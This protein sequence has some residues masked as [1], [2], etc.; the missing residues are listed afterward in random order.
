MPA[1]LVRSL[2]GDLGFASDQRRDEG[3][4][5]LVLIGGSLDLAA[6]LVDWFAGGRRVE[7]GEAGGRG[8]P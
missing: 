3:V 4:W 8:A 6:A 7:A 2:I 5:L 1:L